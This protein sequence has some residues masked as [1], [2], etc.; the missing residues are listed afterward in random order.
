MVPLF[1]GSAPTLPSNVTVLTAVIVKFNI[2]LMKINYEI[3]EILFSIRGTSLENAL[4]PKALV[5]NN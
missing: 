5:R 4:N 2:R 1:N 3:I